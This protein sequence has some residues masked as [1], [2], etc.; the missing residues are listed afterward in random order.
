MN[1]KNIFR[2]DNFLDFYGQEQI[3]KELKVYLYSCKKRNECLDHILFYGP[4][5]VGKSTL[6]CIVAKEMNRN[7]KIINAPVIETVQDLIEI[8]A[9]INEGDVLF[10]DEIHRLEKKIE[11]VL[12]SVLEDFMLYVPYKNKEKRKVI[13]VKLPKFTL[14]GAT[15]I[16]GMLSEPLRERFGIKFHFE[17]YTKREISLIAKN[18][19]NKINL[20]FGN[21]ED[22]LEFADRTKLNPRI[23]NNLVKRLGDFAVYKNIKIINYEVLS[24]FFEFLNIDIYG[25]TEVDKK[26]IKIMYEYF[27]DHP[28]SLENIASLINES[29]VNI[30]EIYEPYLAKIGFINRTRRGRILSKLGK[31][32]YYSRILK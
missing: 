28:V 3:I 31:T 21:D 7:I 9:S 12:Y 6:A 26:I 11:E 32:F 30:R 18:N 13:S 2:V 24:N 10:I 27:E 8:L 20:Q 16:D 1:T 19:L 22:A 17:N 5:G 23:A 15:T 29:V 14:I 25:L 4:S